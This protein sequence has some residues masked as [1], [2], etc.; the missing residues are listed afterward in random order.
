VKK[1]E[2]NGG[3]LHVILIL[4]MKN[5]QVNVNETLVKEQYACQAQEGIG[6]FRIGCSF[7]RLLRSVQRSILPRKNI[8]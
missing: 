5:Q 1:D 7:Q 2:E 4:E 6:K 8:I 3:K